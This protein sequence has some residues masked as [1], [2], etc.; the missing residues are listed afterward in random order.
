VELKL[1]S[2]AVENYEAVQRFEA[3]IGGQLALLTYR[4][5]PSRI[6]FDHTE[7]PKPLEGKG[8]GTKLV[9]AALDFARANHLRVAPLCP[10]V[11][12]YLR[13]HPEY[14]DLLSTED[15]QRV[16]SL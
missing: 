13:K 1:D 6:C 16:L 8:L 12:A 11:A 3:N 9:R 10:F 4:R 5:F 14:Q 2:V 15:L 7:V